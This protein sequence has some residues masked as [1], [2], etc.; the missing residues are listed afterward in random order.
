MAWPELT[1]EQWTFGGGRAR[2]YGAGGPETGRQR[3][4]VSGTSP[5]K[6]EKFCE[7]RRRILLIRH[8]DARYWESNTARVS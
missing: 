2:C 3:R 5:L 6:G 8:P 7:V 4:L 1:L